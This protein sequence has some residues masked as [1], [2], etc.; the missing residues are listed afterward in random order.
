M[1]AACLPAESFL[2]PLGPWGHPVAHL[3]M[4]LDRSVTEE[5][6]VLGPSQESLEDSCYPQ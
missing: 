5:K 6:R 4:R 2:E 3:T 1:L